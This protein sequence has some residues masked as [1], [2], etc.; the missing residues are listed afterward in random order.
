MQGWKK[1]GVI[2][3]LFTERE[4]DVG[5][6]TNQKQ[7]RFVV[8]L[9]CLACLCTSWCKWRK[10]LS[11]LQNVELKYFCVFVISTQAHVPVMAYFTDLAELV[12][13]IDKPKPRSYLSNEDIV[14]EDSNLIF[15]FVSFTGWEREADRL[16]EKET[17]GQSLSN[18]QRLVDTQI[19]R[20]RHIQRET[21]RETDNR[22]RVNK[23][24]RNIVF[25]CI[26]DWARESV[27]VYV[28]VQVDV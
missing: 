28:C 17:E 8:W 11:S 6:K 22:E 14:S 23:D 21:Q 12:S 2:E 26:F 25:F 24:G 1:G 15:N 20:D 4:K 13:K 9:N 5:I 16:R 19:L 7:V 27:F 10:R 18:W 3:K